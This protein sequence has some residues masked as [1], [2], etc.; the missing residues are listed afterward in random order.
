MIADGWLAVLVAFAVGLLI[1]PVPTVVLDGLLA[2]QLG[3]AVVVLLAAVLARDPLTLSQLPTALLLTTL[4]RLALNISTT[5]LILADADAGQVVS[6]FGDAVVRGNLIV[7][8]VVFLVLT[9]V[10]YLVIARGA[11]RVAQVAARF[12]LDGLPGRQLAIDADVRAGLLDPEGARA[13]RTALARESSLFG[14]L[15]GAMKFVRGDAIAG[16]CI[17]GVN[18]VGGL[19]VGIG[20]GGL[21][22]LQAFETYGTLTVGDGL[23]TQVPAMLTATAA[24]LA[25]TRVASTGDASPGAALL[26]ELVGDGRAPALAAALVAVLAVLPGLPFIPLLLTAAALA[27]A[28]VVGRRRAT[29]Q[30]T[31][32]AGD[33]LPPVVPFGLCLHPEAARAVGDPA[34]LLA[35]A[36]AHLRV[37]FGVAAAPAHLR[38]DATE[39]P[40]R[41]YRIDVGEAPIA[42][43]ILPE[44]G[45]AEH[46]LA[47]T[48]AAWRRAGPHLLGMQQVAE[49]LAALEIREPALVRAAVP[50]SVTLPRLAALLRRLLAEDLPVRDLATVLEALAQRP[51]EDASEDDQLRLIRRALAPVI[52]QRVAPDGQVDVVLTDAQLDH[53]LRDELGVGPDLAAEVRESLAS[54]RALRPGAVVLAPPDLRP[55]V[56][57]LIAPHFPGLAVLAAEELLPQVRTTLVGLLPGNGGFED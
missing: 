20:Q 52:S 24:A 19:V 1:F 53:A 40:S 25:V 49:A 43:G 23:V 27:A 15:D 11:E 51:V 9:V 18:V 10:Q 29:P 17:V 44:E 4:M 32:L 2:L 41:G 28:A 42:R 8:V 39:L 57:A 54:V 35:R 36:R 55:A 7:G 37:E 47:V 5:R 30:P 31:R 12:A 56:H 33:P 16:L 45:G 48:A 14:A 3:V 6:A 26:R 21:D 46:L 13:R 38:A 34:A 22:P 50:R